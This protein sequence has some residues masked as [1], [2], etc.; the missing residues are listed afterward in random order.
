M[1]INNVNEVFKIPILLLDQFIL[2]PKQNSYITIQDKSYNKLPISNN[3]IHYNY[4]FN[5]ISNDSL[6]ELDNF[7]LIFLNTK[8]SFST[9]EENIFKLMRTNL[10]V[11]V[12]NSAN[13][14]DYLLKFMTSGSSIEYYPTTF[15][16]LGII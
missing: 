10:L 5:I 15:S 11:L 13:I 8:Q 12:I 16:T 9:I 3:I 6:T 14:N 1:L 2:Q 7:D 4:K